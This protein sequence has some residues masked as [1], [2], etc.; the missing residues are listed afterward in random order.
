MSA[1]LLDIREEVDTYLDDVEHDVLEVTTWLDPMGSRWKV[2]Y[3]FT[4][5]GPTVWL[6]VDSR[7]PSRVVFHH[8]W[9]VDPRGNDYCEVYGRQADEWYAKAEDE[10]GVIFGTLR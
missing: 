9:A 1:D 4:V 5:G 2:E 7:Y 6:E 10:A 3:T 8:S